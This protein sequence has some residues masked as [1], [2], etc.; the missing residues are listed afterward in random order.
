MC[1]RP[2]KQQFRSPGSLRSRELIEG[3]N[4]F[5][6]AKKEKTLKT[7]DQ[8]QIPCKVLAVI[9]IECHEC[10]NGVENIK[11]EQTKPNYC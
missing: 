5:L 4:G 3:R 10:E 11:N 2:E 8:S 1:T 7:I 6:T 9:H